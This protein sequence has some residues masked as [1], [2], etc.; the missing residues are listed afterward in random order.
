[1]HIVIILGPFLPIPP[2]LGGAVEKIHL[3]LAKAYRDAGHEVTII[4]RKFED[5][6]E[7][8]IIN[9]ISYVRIN[10]RNRSPYLALNLAFSFCYA[11]RVAAFLPRADITVTNEFFLPL[12][13]PRQRAGKIYVQVGRFPKY[14]MWLY[15]RADRLQAVSRAVAQAVVRQT[16]WL[17][18]RVRTIGCPVPDIFFQRTPFIRRRVILFVG[19]IAREK[20]V[21]LVIRAFLLLKRRQDLHLI[22]EWKICIVGPHE[23]A[24]G[25]DGEKHLLELKELARPLESQCEFVGPIFDEDAL[26]RKYAESSIFVYPSLAEYGESLGVAAL[27]AMAGRCATVV[28]DLRCFDDYIEHGVTGLKFDHRGHAPEERL[29]EQ[30]A[31]LI[32]EPTFL[33]RVANAGYCAASH[34]SVASIAE[35]MLAD[36]QRLL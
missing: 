30:L 1:M 18:G 32:S 15:F 35:V 34:F 12:V 23:I 17:A 14:Q 9:G 24:A 10:S 21:E 19:R 11:L 16:P 6:P 33:Q 36:F 25:G 3:T 26:H 2:V 8:E 5:F 27:E 28:S 13:L 4:S 31:T 20:G 7:A 22:D 29:A